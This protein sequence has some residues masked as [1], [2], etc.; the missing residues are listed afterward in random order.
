MTI[1][2]TRV[3]LMAAFLAI[4]ETPAGIRAIEAVVTRDG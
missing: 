2:I 3:A 4:L 1:R